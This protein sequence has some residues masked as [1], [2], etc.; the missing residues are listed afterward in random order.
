M[1][2][3]ISLASPTPANSNGTWTKTITGG[4]LTYNR[5][6]GANTDVVYV[7]LNPWLEGESQLYFQSGLSSIELYYNVAVNPL[8][9]VTPTLA[10][11]TASSAFVP[12]RTAVAT[13]EYNLYGYLGSAPTTPVSSATAG[14]AVGNWKYVIDFVNELSSGS[15]VR[16]TTTNPLNIDANEEVQLELSFVVPAGTTLAL[17]HVVLV[18]A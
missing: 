6:A 2:K 4:V 11:V 17:S 15:I 5:A 12:T 1:N 16:S 13:T 10:T 18:A 8:T 14:V 3:V 7:N 9:S